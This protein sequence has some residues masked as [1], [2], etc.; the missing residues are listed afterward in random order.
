MVQ[1]CDFLKAN[2]NKNDDDFLAQLVDFVYL[3]V[4]SYLI[5][6]KRVYS[7]HSDIS[8]L[9]HSRIH[10]A[11]NWV[12][13]GFTCRLHQTSVSPILC[14]REKCP[15]TLLKVWSVSSA[16]RVFTCENAHKGR[17]HYLILWTF[18]SSGLGENKVVSQTPWNLTTTSEFRSQRASNAE[19]VF[20]PSMASSCASPRPLITIVNYHCVV[21]LRT[22]I[23]RKP[24]PMRSLWIYSLSQVWQI[25]KNTPWG[26]IARTFPD[27]L[28]ELL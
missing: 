10:V 13:N 3:V 11:I 26:H 5:I 15:Q 1:V 21:R 14:I 8:C 20:M 25:I 6:W 23:H 12:T 4:T 27:V 24:I 2:R 28:Q 18:L 9:P 7:F 16:H 19:S 22:E 17:T